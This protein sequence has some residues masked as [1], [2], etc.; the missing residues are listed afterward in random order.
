[1]IRNG[2]RTAATFKVELIVV[3]V[4]GFQLLTIITKCP[5]VDVAAG[6]DLSPKYI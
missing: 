1:M 2:S 6:L 4:N 3:I 5:I